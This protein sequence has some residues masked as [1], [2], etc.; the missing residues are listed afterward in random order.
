MDEVTK[1]PAVHWKSVPPP[2]GIVPQPLVALQYASPAVGKGTFTFTVVADVY[3]ETENLLTRLMLV[4][5]AM[6]T[7]RQQSTARNATLRNDGFFIEIPPL[8]PRTLR[9]N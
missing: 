5:L 7:A 4:A 3:G 2:A 8:K 9:G 1:S 6:P